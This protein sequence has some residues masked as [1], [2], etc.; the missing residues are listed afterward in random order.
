MDA[1]YAATLVPAAVP[2]GRAELGHH[3]AGDRTE[4]RLR[5]PGPNG[6]NGD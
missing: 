2:G 1:V 3:R 5:R 6:S 4:V